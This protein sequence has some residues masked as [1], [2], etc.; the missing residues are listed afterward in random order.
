L[1]AQGL[2]IKQIC[3]RLQISE[4]AVGQHF[5]AARRKLGARTLS[6]AA[7]KASFL[8]IIGI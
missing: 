3:E 2:L 1:R 7:F 4:T 5:R 8:E 6:Q